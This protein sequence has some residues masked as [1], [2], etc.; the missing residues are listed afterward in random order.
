MGNILPLN[1]SIASAGVI[2]LSATYRSTA[3]LLVALDITIYL[4]ANICSKDFFLNVLPS[5]SMYIRLPSLSRI[6]RLVY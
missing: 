5:S 6:S 2:G 3:A 1:S 4:S